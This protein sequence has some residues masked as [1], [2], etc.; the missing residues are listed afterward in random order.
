MARELPPCFV[1]ERA[2]TAEERRGLDGLVPPKEQT[3]D[4]RID[5]IAAMYVVDRRMRQHEKDIILAGAVANALY[6]DVG[7]WRR[8]QDLT[9]VSF[10]TARQWVSRWR[11]E[12]ERVD[13]AV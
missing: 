1:D 3:G 2:L 6:R 10:T 8:L 9:G 12:T 11:A 4:T 5:L 7:S 13:T